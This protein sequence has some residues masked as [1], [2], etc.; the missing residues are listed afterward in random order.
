M[1][2]TRV[3][4]IRVIIKHLSARTNVNEICRVNGKTHTVMYEQQSLAN[5]LK[6]RRRN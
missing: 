6:E 1:G 3:L 2:V 5:L 4:L